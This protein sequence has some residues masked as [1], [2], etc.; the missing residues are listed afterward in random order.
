[1]VKY[2]WES[3]FKSSLTIFW[4]SR[5]RSHLFGG[6]VSW[7]GSEDRRLPLEWRRDA[8]LPPDPQTTH[9][10]THTSHKVFSCSASGNLLSL[11][12]PCEGSWHLV[13]VHSNRLQ[14]LP[15][16]LWVKPAPHGQTEH[17]ARSQTAVVRS[18]WQNLWPATNNKPCGCLASL[19]NH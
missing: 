17:S 8:Q 15:S 1:M 5:L 12:S 14:R 19:K 7:R 9:I 13:H 11:T 6:S 3:T 4:N 10:T 16:L 18:S 2:S